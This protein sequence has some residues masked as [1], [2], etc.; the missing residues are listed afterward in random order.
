M[1]WLITSSSESSKVDTEYVKIAVHILS[2]STQDSGKTKEPFTTDEQAL[3]QWAVRLL[4]SKSPEKFT[5]NE[6]RALLATREPFGRIST[7]VVNADSAGWAVIEMLKK[8]MPST[9]EAVP[10]SEK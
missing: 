9:V 5:E 8:S 4:N 10:S 7:D 1:G 3:R 6:Q 2:S